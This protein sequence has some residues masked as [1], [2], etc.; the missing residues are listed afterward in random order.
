MATVEVTNK[1]LEAVNT[2]V[3]EMGRIDANINARPVSSLTTAELNNV[4]A[5]LIH[6]IIWKEHLPL[7][8]LMPKGWMS[9]TGRVRLNI[10]GVRELDGGGRVT[11]DTAVQ[12][13]G[14]FLMPPSFSSFST[15]AVS[16]ED[17]HGW[18]AL[19]QYQNEATGLLDAFARGIKY[20]E[21]VAKW[22]LTQ[23]QVTAFFKSFKTVN[24]AL[25]HTPSMCLYVPKE[26]L[27]RVNKVAA[28]RSRQ[29][30]DTEIPEFDAD[31][32]AAQ[33][34]TLKLQQSVGTAS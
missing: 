10:K 33:A 20:H 2:H 8:D 34:V 30:A 7:R 15:Y 22:K 31:A 11:F 17:L 28:P 18:Q 26:Y 14:K 24:T 29:A 1:F 5:D 19:P 13:E 4:N 21:C 27:D 23:Q 6:A 3:S 16:V 12:I 32:L 25:K 9:D